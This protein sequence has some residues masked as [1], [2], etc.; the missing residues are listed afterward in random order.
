MRRSSLR[1]ALTILALVLS[2]RLLTGAATLI[3][4]AEQVTGVLPAANGGTGATT[5]AQSFVWS[6]CTGTVSTTAGSYFQPGFGG[7][8]A[9]CSG[10]STTSNGGGWAAPVSGTIRNLEVSSSA[11]GK[12]AGTSGT[13]HILINAVSSAVTCVTGNTKT[14]SDLTHTAA[15][16]Q[17]QVITITVQS[18][19]TSET[20]A[21]VVVS[22]EISN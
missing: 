7:S 12:T 19:G 14:C 13:V 9:T 17:G 16:T 15:I 6:W 18:A 11:A 5:F 22:F 1:C 3:N 20:L 4:L 8:S 21:N 10:E 2:V